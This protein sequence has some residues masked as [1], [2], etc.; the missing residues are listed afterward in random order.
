VNW[1]GKYGNPLYLISLFDYLNELTDTLNK[2]KLTSWNIRENI[3]RSSCTNTCHYAMTTRWQQSIDIWLAME[4][5]RTVINTNRQVFKFLSHLCLFY[6]YIY[7]SD[8]K[9]TW[10]KF[11]KCYSTF[12]FANSTIFESPCRPPPPAGGRSAGLPVA[13][14]FIARIFVTRTLLNFGITSSQFPIPPNRLTD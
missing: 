4:A 13:I 6:T 9:L 11:L 5:H 12:L 1:N 10:K 2:F 8:K 7:I 14:F 3:L